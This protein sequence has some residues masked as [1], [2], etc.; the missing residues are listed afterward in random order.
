MSCWTSAREGVRTP[1][2]KAPE[3]RMLRRTTSAIH[4]DT[5]AGIDG[6]CCTIGK[7]CRG[8]TA[9]G[10]LQPLAVGQIRRRG[11][12]QINPTTDTVRRRLWVNA[13]CKGRRDVKMGTRGKCMVGPR[14]WR[15]RRHTEDSGGEWASE[16]LG[17]GKGASQKREE[18]SQRQVFS[19]R[20]PK[21]AKYK[22][23]QEASPERD[24][25]ICGLHHPKG[26]ELLL[27]VRKILTSTRHW[28]EHRRGKLTMSFGLGGAQ[29]GSKPHTEQRGG[30]LG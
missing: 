17:H 21:F 30:C 18:S 26:A 1:L 13:S 23:S 15:L 7:M 14:P 27:S 6:D 19:V 11:D 2:G 25:P 5:R 9:D 8:E 10:G 29:R 16:T 20:P 28:G 3:P 4:E 24:D 12:N 22:A